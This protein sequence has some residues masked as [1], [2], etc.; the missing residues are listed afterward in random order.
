MS[1]VSSGTVAAASAARTVT[2][3]FTCGKPIELP[4]LGLPLA[5]TVGNRLEGLPG[6][7]PV[8]AIG[9]REAGGS[10]M[11]T[12]GLFGGLPGGLLVTGTATTSVAEPVKDRALLPEAVADSCTCSPSAALRPTFTATCSSSACPVGRLPTEQLARWETGQT[13]NRGEPT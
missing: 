9:G 8:P 2:R 7:V 13:V 4:V 11:V 3:G 1:R 12:G 5:P 10:V 6:V